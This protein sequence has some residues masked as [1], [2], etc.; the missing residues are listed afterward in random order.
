MLPLVKRLVSQSDLRTEMER[1]AADAQL[2]AGIIG[3]LVGSLTK[4]RLRLAGA[5]VIK[6]IQGPLEIVSA[7]GTISKDGMHVHVS[8]SDANGQTIG[9]HLVAG[10]MVHT[11]VELVIIPVDGW[12]FD[13]HEDASTGYKELRPVSSS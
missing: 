13:R 10:C 11:T 7:T 1:L 4:A 12:S 9:G 2:D 6:E 3:S 8:L 5:E